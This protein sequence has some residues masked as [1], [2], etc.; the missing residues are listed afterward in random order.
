MLM[1]S[2]LPN[3]RGRIIIVTSSR[4]S[5]SLK[6][7]SQF[8]AGYYGKK[9]IILMDEYDT[10]MQESYVYGYWDEMAAFIR[11]LFN[12]TFKTNPYMERAVLTGITRISKESISAA[13]LP[14][15]SLPPLLLPGSAFPQGC[16]NWYS[17][18]RL[19]N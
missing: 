10:P 18:N 8:L 14:S 1:A 9:V 12:S 16:W 15:P 6:A 3:R 11:S 17:P 7:L 4:F 2:V 5:Y 19:Q 13:G